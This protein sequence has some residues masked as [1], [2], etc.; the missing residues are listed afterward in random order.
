MC[1]H[2][3]P[4]LLFT[5]DREDN[6]TVFIYGRPS[7]FDS[8]SS[9]VEEKSG[10]GRSGQVREG[11]TRINKAVGL[12]TQIG[13][14]KGCGE[15]FYSLVLVLIPSFYSNNSLWSRFHVGF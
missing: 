6:V 9:I 5:N 3:D 14:G 2:G 4:S 15:T 1:F 7:D 10:D 8:E 12:R 11:I 13:Q